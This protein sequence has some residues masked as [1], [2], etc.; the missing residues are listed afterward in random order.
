MRNITEELGLDRVNDRNELKHYKNQTH[1]TNF[2]IPNGSKKGLVIFHQNIRGLNSNKL[3]ELFVFLPTNPPHIICFT[4]HHLGNNEIDTVVLNNYS[5]GAK[6]CRNTF[7][8]GG[9]CIF[10]YE[11][12]QFTDINIDKLCKEKDLDICAVK[13]HL[14]TSEICVITIC[15][16][17]FGNFQYFIDNL[18]KILRLIYCNNVEIIIC[19]DININYLTDSTHKQLQDSL[20][21]SYGLC[22]TVKFPT[23]IQN[24]SHSAIDNIFINTV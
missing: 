15:R 1:L 8:N 21:A 6:F 16:S 12:I 2:P 4:E 7:K 17:P 22:S 10:T 23:K 20:L 24:N 13:W 5:L 11:S 3:D 14:P 19:G 18:E 9:V